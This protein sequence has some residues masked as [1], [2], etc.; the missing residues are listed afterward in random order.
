MAFTDELAPRGDR[1]TLHPQDAHG[2]LDL[3][4]LL[5]TLRP[6]PSSTAAGPNLC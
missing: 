4:A 5:G 6:T 2:L 1:V 3:D